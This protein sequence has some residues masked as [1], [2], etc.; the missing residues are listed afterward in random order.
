[1]QSFSSSRSFQ[2]VCRLLLIALFTIACLPQ[3]ANAETKV[4]TDADKATDIQ[5]KVGDVL[6]VRLNANPSTGFKWYIHPRST[7][8]LRLTGETQ[9]AGPEP[10]ADR[11][12]VQ[13]FTFEIK[14][15]GD[16]ILLMRYAPAKE[17]P[18]LGEEQYSL[19]VIID[20]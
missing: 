8:L 2:W 18:Q 4:A 7:A 16:G 9:A 12:M 6:E 13:V 5:V 17:K 19:H 1:M 3:M 20:P 14:K 10:A 15:K 11:P